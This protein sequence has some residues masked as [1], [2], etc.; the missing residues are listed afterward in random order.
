MHETFFAFVATPDRDNYLKLRT[1][2]VGCEAYDPYND[3]LLDITQMVERQQFDRAAK[4]L[5]ESMPNLL[6]SPRAHALYAAIAAERGDEQRAEAERFV[7][8]LC[9][10]GML[11]CGDGSRERPYPVLRTSDEYDVLEFLGKLPACQ[12]LHHEGDR[13]LDRLETTDGQELW[14]DLTDAYE[15][16]SET[17][18][19]HQLEQLLD[20]KQES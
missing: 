1:W 17:R 12:S 16:V 2:L 5:E 15:K 10:Q 13:Q 3:N 14:F 11:A 20:E 6:L 19:F 9:V 4:A 7:A 18:L 8:E